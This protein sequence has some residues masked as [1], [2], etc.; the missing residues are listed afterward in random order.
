[1]AASDGRPD[2]DVIIIG[3]GTAGCVAASRL[4]EDPG[5]RVLLLEAGPDPQPVPDLV[6][7]APRQPELVL[8][9]PWVRMYETSRPDGSTFPLLAGR[10]IGGGSSVNNMSVIRP[11]GLDFERWSTFGGAAWSYDAQLPVMRALEADQDFP[12]S[13]LHGRDGPVWV[14]RQFTLD[15]PADPP[16]AGLIEA[17]SDLGLPKCPDLNVPEPLGICASPYNVRDGRRAGV[18]T[19]YL[20]PARSRPNLEIRADTLVRRLVIEG[21]RVV[22]VEADTP[23]GPAAFRADRVI[24]SGGVFHSPQV[25]MLSGIGPATELERLGLPVVLDHPGVG[26]NYHDHSVTYVTYEGTSDLREDWVIPKLRLIYASSESAGHGDFHIFQRPA[27]RLAGLPPLLAFSVHLLE[28]RNRGRLTLAS[29]DPAAD[30]VIENRMLE[31][32]R[33]VAAMVDAMR[34]VDR[35]ARH[36]ALSPFYGRRLEPADDDW[37]SFA[38][39]TYGTY[40]H[41]VG[42]C[43]FGRDEDP[44][45]VTDPGLRLRGLDNLWVADASVLPVVPHA[46][47][48]VSVMLTGEAVA[49]SVAAA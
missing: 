48:N 1:M 41:G 29:T 10:L 4:S 25:L 47:T 9:S 31:D 27:T 49:R 23:D 26:A 39:S 43:R 17:A 12:D 15:M 24:L 8:G 14:Q 2:A 13:P 28:Q 21:A 3:G 20:D 45:A 42:T 16:V 22:G 35:L 38:H 37:A 11:I 18:V 19:G 33:D 7:L 32:E 40:Y 6:A 30:P 36:A 5:R 44:L 46:N 34:F